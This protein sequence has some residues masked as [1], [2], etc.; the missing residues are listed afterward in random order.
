M[1]KDEHKHKCATCSNSIDCTKN[2]CPI[3]R[4]AYIIC[5]DCL[6]HRYIDGRYEILYTEK[7]GIG[8]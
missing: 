5:F 6:H 4:V 3:G 1:Q 8:G 2:P 7:K